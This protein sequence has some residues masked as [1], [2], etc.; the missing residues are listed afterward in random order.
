MNINLANQIL[1]FGGIFA[2]ITGLIWV[3]WQ[4]SQ[5]SPQVSKESKEY[6]YQKKYFAVTGILIL[7]PVVIILFFSGLV[8][9]DT[10]ARGTLFSLMFGILAPALLSGM[11][12]MIFK[13]KS[14]REKISL[15]VF[16]ALPLLAIGFTI[17]FI[18]GVVNFYGI[19]AD[20][21]WLGLILGNALGIFLLRLASHFVNYPRYE[22][23]AIKL[24]ALFLTLDASIISVLM[25]S[26]HFKESIHAYLPGL[27]LV[28]LFFSILICTILFSYRPEKNVMEILPG[29]FAIFLLLF[30]LI[31]VFLIIKL[32][33][34]FSYS[35]PL[36]AGAISSIIFVIILYSSATNVKGIDLSTGTLATLML[37]GGIWFSYKWNLGF[38]ITMYAVGLL[39]V[40]MLLIPH[41]SMENFL[42]FVNTEKTDSPITGAGDPLLTGDV[43]D[44]QEIEATG[45][46]GQKEP[47]E[48]NPALEDTWAT[49]FLRGISLA[50]L[51]VVLVSM[52]RIFIQ[53]TDS[54]G[55][56]INIVDGDNIVALLLGVFISLCFEGFNL[57]G[58]NIFKKQLEGGAK[59]AASLFAIIIVTAVAI[60]FSIIIFFR[61]QGMGSFLLGLSIPALLGLYT[62]FSQ[63]INKGLYKASLS[64]LWLAAGAYA[65]F[66]IIYEEVPNQLT[67]STKQEIVI[68]MIFL[69]ILA[70]FISHNQN[71]TEKKE[72][73]EPLTEKTPRK[74]NTTNNN[75]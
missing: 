39:S 6:I 75:Q 62:F 44:N 25:A 59:K 49:L 63:K 14:N 10:T 71:K 34:D 33:I 8:K 28:A 69:V 42:E 56:N 65:N 35:Y 4:M 30:I 1:W 68:G 21:L 32:N 19:N 58:S 5:K 41:N 2:T 40:V 57:S 53:R 3:I 18:G 64:M 12:S 20:Q 50:G 31:S 54:L 72:I 47:D 60:I 38:G 36:I 26:Y 66:L 48:K 45:E 43:Q 27:I 46:E 67:R 13:K 11:E 22:I 15:T 9:A 37:I 23:S 29:Q 51:T 73:K 70:Y 7:I 16:A 52:F 61:I 74:S 17:M 24:E 55:F